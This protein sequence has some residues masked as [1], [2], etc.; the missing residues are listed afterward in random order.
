MRRFVLSI[1][2]SA[3]L[4]TLVTG[5]GGAHRYDAR[6]V[7]ADSLMLPARDSALAVVEGITDTMLRSERDL[8]YRDLLL[9]QARYKCYAEITA[10]DDS[11]ITRAMDYFGTHSGDREKLT[12]A[13]LYKGAVMEELGHVDSAMFYYKTAEVNA[14]EKD[15]TNLG[16]IN[17]RIANLYRKNYGDVQTC[18]EK[19]RLAY[20]CHRL[21]GNKKMQLNN[22]CCMFIMNGITRLNEQDTLF[23]RAIDLAH[24][25]KDNKKLCFLYELR[26][27]QLSREDSTSYK[28]KQI[29]FQLLNNYS[30]FINN[31]LLLDLAYLYAK[32][33]KP[34]SA[35]YFLTNVDERLE[36]D[37]KVRVIIRKNEVLSIIAQC[38]GNPS[39]SHLYTAASS[40]LTDSINDNREK[41][42]IESIEN[43][44][45]G[46]KN[47]HNLSSIS[48]LQWAIIGLSFI[49]IVVILLLTTTYL[50]RLHRIKCIIKDLKKMNNEHDD[51]ML[52]KLDDKNGVIERLLTNLVILMNT[53]DGNDKQYSTSRLAQQIKSTI[54]DVADDKFW[55]EL[56]TYLDRKHNGIIS[57]IEQTQDISESDL[58]FIMLSCCGFSYVVIAIIMDYSPRY[59]YA[60][61]KIIAKKMGIEMPLQEYLDSLLTE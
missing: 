28:A 39:I 54:V 45:N 37:D 32:E 27:N 40:R 29:A 61:R 58:K 1:L 26:C 6:L 18:Y 14:D 13:T 42:V 41:Y 17:T 31:D 38:E 19:Y 55:A 12:R 4:V 35:R 23:N 50:H 60:K 10:A 3:I 21:S 49:A 36:P 20:R 43:E 52:N 8:A 16:Q 48:H 51:K 56:K 30:E 53:V 5:C 7:A 22:L 9:T 57:T 2:I 15:Y 46:L 44:F 25:L 33:N 11:A 34:D 24:E 59:V 47:N